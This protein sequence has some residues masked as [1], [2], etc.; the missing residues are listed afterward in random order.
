MFHENKY[1]YIMCW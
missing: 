1:Y